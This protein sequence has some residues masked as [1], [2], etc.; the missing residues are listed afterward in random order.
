MTLYAADPF[1]L[2]CNIT[3]NSKVSLGVCLHTVTCYLPQRR[4]KCTSLPEDFW[5]AVLHPLQSIHLHH[6][7]AALV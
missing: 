2:C 1:D 3:Q 5:P 4:V 7:L 6:N